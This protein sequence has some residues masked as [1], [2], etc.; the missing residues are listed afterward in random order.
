[1]CQ[2]KL[3]R[4]YIESV[5][6]DE[7]QFKIPPTTSRYRDLL[8]AKLNAIGISTVNIYFTCTELITVNY[9]YNSEYYN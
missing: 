4:K 3:N 7:G 5:K 8:L 6:N 9:N 2:Y 1:M